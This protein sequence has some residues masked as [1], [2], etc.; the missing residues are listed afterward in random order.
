MSD[1]NNALNSIIAKKSFK[2]ISWDIKNEIR[3]GM[4]NTVPTPCNNNFELVLQKTDLNILFQ[5]LNINS[6]KIEFDY[7]DFLSKTKKTETIQASYRSVTVT[8][9]IDNQINYKD[10]TDK[11][12]TSKFMVFLNKRHCFVN[13]KKWSYAI[14]FEED[15]KLAF[16]FFIPYTDTV[17]ERKEI[18][19]TVANDFTI[20]P[21]FDAIAIKTYEIEDFRYIWS[22]FHSLNTF[23]KRI[24]NEFY[25][26]IVKNTTNVSKLNDLYKNLPFECAKEFYLL[27]NNENN[28]TLKINDVLQHYHKLFEYD[29]NSFFK[30]SSSA[31]VKLL[32]I[33][34]NDDYLINY[35]NQNPELL[36][37]VYWAIDGESKYE[38]QLVKNRTI[39]TS[40]INEM[41]T[42]FPI[43]ERM[44]GEVFYY[45]KNKFSIDSNVDIDNDAYKDKIFLKQIEKVTSI[46]TIPAGYH[47]DGE[48]GGFY[49]PET[50]E[51]TYEYQELKEGNYHPLDILV[52]MYEGEMMTVPAIF[53]KSIAD[54]DEWKEIFF[55]IRIVGNVITF[56][57]GVVTLGSSS[58]FLV[59][60]AYVDIGYSLLDT[61]VAIAEDELRKTE[62][63]RAFLDAWTKITLGV[64]VVNAPL[65]LRTIFVNGP[66]LLL[67][68][69][70]ATQATM[71]QMMLK[72]I[73]EVN[74]HNFDGNT[75]KA[76]LP[77]EISYTA[78]GITFDEYRKFFE[79]G[80]MLLEGN[81]INNINGAK[82][83]AFTYQGTIIF[84]G[85]ARDT[86]YKET[87]RSLVKNYF[88]E[89]KLISLLEE[90]YRRAI[91]KKV[92]IH[93][94]LGDFSLPPNPKKSTLSGKMKGGGHGQEN[95]D[96][97]EVINRKYKIEHTYSNGVR[98]GAVDGH[99][100][101]FKRLLEDK[102][103]T[104]QSW[105]PKNWDRFK[106]KEA[107]Q[108]VIINNH[109]KYIKAKDGIEP[110][111]D[112]FE[113]VRVGVMKTNGKPA[114]IFPDN[115]KQPM[116]NKKEFEINPFKD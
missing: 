41:L 49:Q 107:G 81:T 47:R 103:N 72:V 17:A 73:L 25:H 18:K 5:Y 19:E 13:L 51:E 100:S 60:L 34:S 85:L 33:L 90:L 10:S 15:N 110:I 66:R 20:N 1:T 12:R 68:A 27:C 86:H 114:T 8:N 44:K 46:K 97:L 104:G 45:E 82:Q 116:K 63:G 48:G 31:I 95:I 96:F 77:K 75:V 70:Q 3:N 39:F 28:G 108:Y 87:V 57:L 4:S 30:D 24:A 98:I 94:S 80:C 55:I 62:E 89:E 32:K 64:A 29:N 115:A 76:I 67:K 42:R 53:I 83:Y 65:L 61:G 37:K 109:E 6:E 23:Y 88:Y 99:N 56:A 22:K 92:I 106:I 40:I 52:L 54:E 59:A 43:K 105:F 38:E 84:Q 91:T 79:N 112:V 11:N 93:A 71:R 111:F 21:N 2:E 101:N 36:K 16:S 102:T 7:R 14:N 50:E 35:Y 58:P 78:T 74:I 113:G 69:S 26:Q 9:T